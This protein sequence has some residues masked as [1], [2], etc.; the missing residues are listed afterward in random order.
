MNYTCSKQDTTAPYSTQPTTLHS[1]CKTMQN[2]IAQ[3]HIKNPMQFE[4]QSNNY[5]SQ[6]LCNFQP[7]HLKYSSNETSKASTHKQIIKVM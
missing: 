3:S 6:T 1:S 7:N 5:N 2:R 4:N